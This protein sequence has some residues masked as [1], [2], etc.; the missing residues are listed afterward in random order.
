MKDKTL[1]AITD[2][3]DL[4]ASGKPGKSNGKIT[5]V[6]LAREAG[7]SKAT[8]YRYLDQNTDL[9]EAYNA[10]RKNGV[11]EDVVV[12][13]TIEQANRLLKAEVKQLR[14]ELAEVR[15]Q[16][17]LSNKLKAHQIQL[18]WLE[19]E[20]LQGEITRLLARQGD[21]V[22]PLVADVNRK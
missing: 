12:P 9:Q 6:N 1:Q 15:R 18:L 5:G 8:L 19:N 16:A 21:N 10:L 7:V 14:S 4:L 13:E 17:D 2:A 22:V 11:R 20:R 3:L